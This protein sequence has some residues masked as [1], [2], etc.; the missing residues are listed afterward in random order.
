M[1]SGLRLSY[2]KASRQKGVGENLFTGFSSQSRAGAVSAPVR[3]PSEEAGGRMCTKPARSNQMW[4]F[5]ARNSL[6]NTCQPSAGSKIWEQTKRAAHCPCCKRGVERRV[7]GKMGKKMKKAKWDQANLNELIRL[8]CNLWSLM[9]NRHYQFFQL[10]QKKL[11]VRI[12]FLCFG[13]YCPF[14]GGYVL[15]V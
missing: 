7:G 15:E 3:D 2:S 5:Y 4:P 6:L 1:K 9:K 8:K 13:G 12:Q 14:L 10:C 11:R